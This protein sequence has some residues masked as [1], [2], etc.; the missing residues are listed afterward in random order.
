M[1]SI[2]TDSHYDYKKLFDAATGEDIS[3]RET[4]G[5]DGDG[6]YILH[7][8]ETK[9]IGSACSEVDEY[10]ILSASEYRGLVEKA[11][12]NRQISF[13]KRRRL[14]KAAD[15]GR[16]PDGRIASFEIVTLRLSGMRYINDYEIVMNGENAE[17][18]RYAVG[19]PDGE[20]SR[21]LEKRAVCGEERIID[22]LNGCRMLSWNGFYGK[23]PRGVKDGT[24]FSL[25]ATVNGGIKI[26]ASGSQNFPR[27]FHDFEDGMYKILEG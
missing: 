8:A 18:S 16:T 11:R 5:L 24:M 23:H 22:L 25:R 10:Y 12:R 15:D 27:H 19:Y 6:N 9:N 7:V 3:R 4:V 20:E 1:K 14:L 2:G 21:R 17:V 26:E 13:L